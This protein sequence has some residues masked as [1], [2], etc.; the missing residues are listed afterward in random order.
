M[1][2]LAFWVFLVDCARPYLDGPI[3]DGLALWVAFDCNGSSIATGS[4]LAVD[5]DHPT[6][7]SDAYFHE[8]AA[9]RLDVERVGW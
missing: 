7:T 5:L 9:V 2:G 6:P 3:G 8:L 1:I 4:V